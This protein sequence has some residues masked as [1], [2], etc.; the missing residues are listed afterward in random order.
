MGACRVSEPEFE[1]F[2]RL[3]RKYGMR[4]KSDFFRTCL[5]KLFEA[6]AEGNLQLPID[7]ARTEGPRPGRREKA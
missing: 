1:K 7:L 2:G 4:R 6:D 3:L 5:E